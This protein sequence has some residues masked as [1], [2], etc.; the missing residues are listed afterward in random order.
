MP[1]LCHPLSDVKRRSYWRLS[2]RKLSASAIT[3]FARGRLT[4]W[5]QRRRECDDF[6]GGRVRPTASL[7]IAEDEV[8]AVRALNDI[9]NAHRQ[10]L[11]VDFAEVLL[12]LPW[13]EPSKPAKISA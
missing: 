2:L 9:G 5:K 6:P 12:D 3:V 7:Q 10:R 1:E 8:S 11:A 4:S 13:L